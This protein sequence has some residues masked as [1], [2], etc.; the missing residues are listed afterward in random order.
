MANK[1]KFFDDIKLEWDGAEYTIPSSDVMGAIFQ[2]EKHVT[3]KELAIY[4]KDPGSVRYGQLASAYQALLEYAGVK[5]TIEDVYEKILDIQSSSK[6]TMF[7]SV[8]ALMALMVPP[9]ALSDKVE[10]AAPELTAKKERGA[11]E[12]TPT[13]EG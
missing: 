11:G 4:S 5:I 3:L 10:A 12:G 9:K 2:V 1:S 13:T 7:R 8:L 6:A